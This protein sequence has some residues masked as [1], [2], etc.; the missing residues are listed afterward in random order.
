VM[1]F[2]W[3]GSHTA[4]TAI[5]LIVSNASRRTGQFVGEWQVSRSS[6]GLL[7]L[8]VGVDECA[9]ERRYLGRLLGASGAKGKGAAWR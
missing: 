8:G 5:A 9:S 2:A 6:A 4:S 7:E 1:A 3:L